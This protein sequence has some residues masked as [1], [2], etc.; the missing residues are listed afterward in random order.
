[1]FNEEVGI[2]VLPREWI[3]LVQGLGILVPHE[4]QVSAEIFHEFVGGEFARRVG[5]TFAEAGPGKV[6][7][8]RV[9]LE[10]LISSAERVKTWEVFIPPCFRIALV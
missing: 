8:E 9:N 6:L 4:M 7:H 10:V 5:Q 1:M 2:E 3:P